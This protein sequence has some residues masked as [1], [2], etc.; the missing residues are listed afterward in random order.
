MEE[1]DL[2][3]SEVQ[4]ERRLHVGCYMFVSDNRWIKETWKHKQ[5]KGVTQLGMK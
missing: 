4:E 1:E 3:N 2:N 5:G